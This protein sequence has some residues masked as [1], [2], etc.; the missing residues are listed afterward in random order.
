MAGTRTRY[1][2][3]TEFTSSS[4]VLRFAE[5]LAKGG[6]IIEL[7]LSELASEL[8]VVLSKTTGPGLEKW[9]AKRR[10]K[11]VARMVHKAAEGGKQISR[12]GV[13]LAKTYKN[14]Y[15][16]EINPPK[17]RPLFDFQG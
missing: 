5:T 11:K 4:D 8:E 16:D 2:S 3:H 7:E 1:F 17:T 6:Q 10:A 15:A 14:E 13:M 9:V 12:S